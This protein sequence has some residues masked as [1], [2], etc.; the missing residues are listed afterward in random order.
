[1]IKIQYSASVSG[2]SNCFTFSFSYQDYIPQKYYEMGKRGTGTELYYFL[3]LL[4]L[5]NMFDG[6]KERCH[7]LIWSCQYDCVYKSYIPFTL[8][9]DMDYDMVSFA[10]DE[11]C[12]AYKEEIAETI[13]NLMESRKI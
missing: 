5:N 1:M 4:R 13:K 8:V 9:Y 12:I 2:L 6:K 7:E 3:D 11:K 10:V